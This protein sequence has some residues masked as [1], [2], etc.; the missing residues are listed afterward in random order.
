[1]FFVCCACASKR[2]DAEDGSAGSQALPGA[3]RTLADLL[4]EAEASQDAQQS[5]KR[6]NGEPKQS[7]QVDAG[8]WQWNPPVGADTTGGTVPHA[9]PG[10]A[11]PN[12][13]GDTNELQRIIDQRNKLVDK[14]KFLD[15][16]RVI[17]RRGARPKA[18]AQAQR[19][20]QPHVPRWIEL[21]RQMADFLP[22]RFDD[23]HR[24]QVVGVLEAA[25]RKRKDFFE[26]QVLAAIG[27]AYDGHVT[28]ATQ[29][30]DGAIEVIE[31]CG[32]ALYPSLVAHDCAYACILAGQPEKV[33]L[34]IKLIKE[35][36]DATDQYQRQQWLVAVYACAVGNEGDARTYFRRVLSKVGFIQKRTVPVSPILVGDAA[37]FFLTQSTASLTAA[38]VADY[39][40]MAEQL[41]ENVPT[42]DPWVWQ[43][44]RAKA[45]LA[46][47]QGEWG[48]AL[49]HLEDCEEV[50]PRTIDAE[51]QAVK[52][53]YRDHPVTSH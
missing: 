53:G 13:P 7:G 19:D 10:Q 5:A 43:L 30:L 41:L 14:C 8:G 51:V 37:F 39:K 27:R 38:Q 36:I 32:S 24:S 49:K 34:F 40:Q 23:P 28:E 16:L 29:H 45:A 9:G 1:M 48:T 42:E 52:A 26:A 18:L 4:E 31:S 20:L 6:K 17:A 21:Y 12:P 3:H 44:L 46:A 15:N 35:K 47:D 2:T 33:E 50:C 11:L 25:I 22:P